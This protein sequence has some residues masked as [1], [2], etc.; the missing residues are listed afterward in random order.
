MTSQHRREIAVADLL[1]SCGAETMAVAQ[2]DSQAFDPTPVSRW[3]LG[4]GSAGGVSG[5]T[6]SG[7]VSLMCAFTFRV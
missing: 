6:M 3:G 1:P 7:S 2:M 4:S 5:S